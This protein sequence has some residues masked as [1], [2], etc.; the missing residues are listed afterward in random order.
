MTMVR[1]PGIAILIMTMVLGALA[2]APPR[3]GLAAESAPGPESHFSVVLTPRR[4]A[5]ISSEVRAQVTRIHREFGQ[6]F[7][8]GTPLIEMDARLHRLNLERAEAVLEAARSNHQINARLFERESASLMDLSKAKM[9][10]AVA[11]VGRRLAL[12]ELENCRVLAPYNGRVEKLFVHEHELVEP[13]RPLVKVVDDSVLRARVILPANLFN[14]FK[15]GQAI[16][17]QVK[18]ASAEVKGVVS[19]ISAVLDPASA[20]FEVY[21]EVAN[22]RTDLRSGMTGRLLPPKSE[23]R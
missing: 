8:S 12:Q 1:S 17:I 22:P 4:E 2:L 16:H 11:E 7:T 21:A 3:M 20:T 5:I 14:S 23:G 15:I 18:E 19:H 13:G 6:S 9:D 10:L